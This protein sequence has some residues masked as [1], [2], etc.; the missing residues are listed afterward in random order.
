M[1]PSGHVRSWNAGAQKIKGYQPAGMVGEHFSRFYTPEDVA[2]GKPEE[3]CGLP[4]PMAAGRKKVGASARMAPI[5]GPMWLS[6]HC[7][8]IT[9]S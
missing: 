4:P 1:D 5:S 6:P 7:E 3:G 8:A 2:R 9:A